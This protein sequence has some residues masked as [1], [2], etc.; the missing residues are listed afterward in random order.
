MGEV[1]LE[2]MRASIASRKSAAVDWEMNAADEFLRR[3]AHNY[4]SGNE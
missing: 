4:R 1:S 3:I 2:T